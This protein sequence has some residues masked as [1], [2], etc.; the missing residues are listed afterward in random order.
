MV[1]VFGLAQ[2]SFG[3]LIL[4]GKDNLCAIY[5]RSSLVT[6]PASTSS[7]LLGRAIVSSSF[8]R[9][10]IQAIEAELTIGTYLLTCLA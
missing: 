10:S 8:R 2:K 1:T 3:L 4:S 5:R 9:F 7:E 6:A